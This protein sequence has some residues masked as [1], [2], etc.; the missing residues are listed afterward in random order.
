MTTAAFFRVIGRRWYIILLGLALAG[1]TFVLM[2][3]AGGTYTA[4]SSVIFVAPG[5]SG[6]SQVQ[7]GY[8]PSLVDYAAI[9]ERVARNGQP[10]D[11]L[12][13]NDA[14]LFGAG[15]TKGY[16]IELPNTGGQ[17]AVSFS[18]P[19][20]EISVVGPSSDW[21][22]KTMTHQLA[23]VETIARDLQS[24]GGS[25]E[26]NSITT[27]ALPT[28][29]VV[30]YQGATR[31]TQARALLALIILGLG[32]S[33]VVAVLIDRGSDKSAELIPSPASQNNR[34]PQ[35]QRETAP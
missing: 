33:S 32:L 14:T 31:S 16:T 9:V 6:V 5:S 15:V 1:L 10:A 19:R 34:L 17:W 4:E 23:R 18:Q 22:T 7:D 25:S 24:V 20:L 11:R 28:V 35:V 26:A 2:N 13:S 21:V 29:P 30:Q 12:A 27:S 3:R 8:L